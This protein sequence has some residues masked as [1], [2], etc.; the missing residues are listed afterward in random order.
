[1]AA[2]PPYVR[3]FLA[4]VTLSLLHIP[5]PYWGNL[6]LHR[7]V[8]PFIH[9]QPVCSSSLPHTASRPLCVADNLNFMYIP[10]F[11]SFHTILTLHVRVREIVNWNA[12]RC[13][14]D[15]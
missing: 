6:C 13:T 12:N 14:S 7:T 15:V 1:M 11:L 9:P 3:P 8:I 2:F 5:L 10:V 4:R